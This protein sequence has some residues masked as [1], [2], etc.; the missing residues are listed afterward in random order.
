MKIFLEIQNPK[1]DPLDC[2]LVIIILLILLITIN[3]KGGDSEYPYLNPLDGFK[4]KKVPIT[5]TSCI[6]VLF[7]NLIFLE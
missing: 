4:N 6:Y 7:K 5:T 1:K 3:N 2:T